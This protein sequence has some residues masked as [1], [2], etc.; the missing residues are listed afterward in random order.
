MFFC[1]T[2]PQSP[3]GRVQPGLAEGLAGE[4]DP[5]EIVVRG[6]DQGV[7]FLQHGLDVGRRKHAHSIHRPREGDAFL[8]Y[9]AGRVDV[10]QIDQSGSQLL[11]RLHKALAEKS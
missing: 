9:V 4:Q 6:Y 2:E 3:L 8:N 10:I 7:P 1:A 5:G 11:Q